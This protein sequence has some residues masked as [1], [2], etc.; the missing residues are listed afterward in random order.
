MPR[1][2]DELMAVGQLWTK[3]RTLRRT[4]Y[5]P[6]TAGR[7]VDQ[8][9][10]G[11]ATLI[12]AARLSVRDF[13]TVATLFVVASLAGSVADWGRSLAIVRL[14]GRARLDPGF[15]RVARA[16]N[17]LIAVVCLAL[18]LVAARGTW[19]TVIISAGFVWALTAE[20]M[21]SRAALISASRESSLFRLEATSA[22]AA[23]I[24]LIG[25]SLWHPRSA[26]PAALIVRSLVVV[27]GGLASLRLRLGGVDRPLTSGPLVLSQGLGY[28]IA[29]VDYIIAL[30]V[31]GPSVLG[32]Y[33]LGFRAANLAPAQI[34]SAVWPV[35][36]NELSGDGGYSDRY[37]RLLRSV[38]ALGFGAAVCTSL[39]APILPLVLGGRW[40]DVV[41]V[42]LLLVPAI[43]FRLTLGLAGSL[44]IARGLEARLVTYET[45][46]LGGTVT[47]LVA[48]SLLGAGA[49]VC[50]V[51]LATIVSHG[52]LHAAAARATE[53]APYN[54]WPNLLVVSC[55]LGLAAFVVP[56]LN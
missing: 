50:A 23:L 12:L 43:P 10:M 30:S 14:H 15:I 2:D 5:G 56:G 39:A 11:F 18:G 25:L 46:R 42:I 36:L 41:P 28:A 37:R 13:G 49:F 47:V 3:L 35:A 9:A 7:I 55:Q 8:G 51:S 33:V 24:V 1:I 54:W 40:A 44:L 22:A 4:R 27:A 38:L 34:S 19:Q 16:R 53:M 45:W 52:L 32:V 26:L 6:V 48:A 20:Q 17:S 21:M 31:L 29:N